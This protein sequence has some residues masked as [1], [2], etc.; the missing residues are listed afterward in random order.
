M[1]KIDDLDVAILKELQENGRASYREL[2]RKF[3]VPHTTVFTRASRLE[4]VGVD[5]RKIIRRFMAILLPH[6]LGLQTNF[7]I[8]EV[9]PAHS[10]ETAKWLSNFKEILNVFRTFDGKIIAEVVVTGHE[11][12]EDFLSRLG[13]VKTTSYPIHEVV[14]SDNTISESMLKKSPG[15]YLNIKKKVK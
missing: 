13:D 11:E 15:Y 7:I 14:K 2:G 3:G 1:K 9:H 10:Q 5:T 12:F 4:G 6:E 8:V